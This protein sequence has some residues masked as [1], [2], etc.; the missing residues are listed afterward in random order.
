MWTYLQNNPDSIEDGFRLVSP[1]EREVG[2][3]DNEV[4]AKNIVDLLNEALQA[5]QSRGQLD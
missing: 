1:A 3:I 4:D 2:I 5:R